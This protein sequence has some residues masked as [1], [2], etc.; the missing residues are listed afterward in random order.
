[1]IMLR[2]VELLFHFVIY[3]L[4]ENTDSS[5]VVGLMIIY[6]IYIDLLNCDIRLILLLSHKYCLPFN[7]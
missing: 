1:M 5:F 2:V 6:L 4:L 3:K 7:L